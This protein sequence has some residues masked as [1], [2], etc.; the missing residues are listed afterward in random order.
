MQHLKEP[1]KNV[2]SWELSNQ[3]SNAKNKEKNKE[4]KSNIQLPSSV[5][6]SE[7][8]ENE[9]QVQVFHLFIF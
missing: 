5:F 1:G 6:A 2:V 7:F 8:E 4:N 9:G 3:P